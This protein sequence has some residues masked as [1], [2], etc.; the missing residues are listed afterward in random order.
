MTFVTAAIILRAMFSMQTDEAI[1]RMKNAVETM[2]G[3]ADRN[4]TGS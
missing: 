2:S 4:Q 1:I 3:Y